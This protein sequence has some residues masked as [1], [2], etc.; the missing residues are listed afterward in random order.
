MMPGMGSGEGNE[1]DQEM[2]EE[3]G[4]IMKGMGGK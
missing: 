2:M 4:R 1:A 3:A